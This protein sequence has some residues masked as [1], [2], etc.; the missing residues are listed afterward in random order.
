VSSKNPT[1]PV[2]K[3]LM[4]LALHKVHTTGRHLPAVIN[5]IFD[6]STIEAGRKGGG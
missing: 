2:A 3:S 5:D 4:Q 1:I 6:L